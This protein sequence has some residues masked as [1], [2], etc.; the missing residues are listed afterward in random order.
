M[1]MMLLDY[2][3]PN[4]FGETIG[5][6]RHLAW[7]VNVY[8]VT[9]PKVPE[10]GE[11]LNALERVILKLIDAGGVNEVES[12]ANETCIPKDL[13]QCVLLRLQDKS[14]LDEYNQVLAKQRD[15]WAK[16]EEHQCVYVTALLFRELTSGKILPYL[17]FLQ[18][19]NPL[20]KKEE[21]GSFWKL[22]WDDVHR[23]SQPTPRDVISAL[24]GMQLRAIAFGKEIRR[25]P[26]QL[27][28]I[29]DDAELNYLDCPIAIQKSDGE[30]RIADPFGSGC[31]L[32]L[33]NAFGRLLE[34]DSNLGDRFMN[35]K[36]N[37][38]NGGS[39]KRAALNQEPYDNEINWSRYP[40][41]V[42][43]LKLHKKRHRNIQQIHAAI[44]WALFYSCAQRS[45]TS[46]VSRLKLKNQSEHPAL[47][48]KA[49]EDIS[50][51]LP[52]NGLRPLQE[53]KLGS[54]LSGKAELGTVLILSLLMAAGD[55]SHPLHRIASSHQD[56]ITRLFKIKKERDEIGH[57]TGKYRHK[58]I[59]LPEEV[60][61]REVVS[62]LLPTVRFSDNPVSEVNQEIVADSLLDARTSLQ[63]EFGFALFNRLGTNLQDR[64]IGA[65]RFWL[66][67]QDGD[68]ALAFVCDLYAALQST[69]RRSLTGALP[70]EVKDTEYCAKAQE[71]ADAYGLGRLPECLFTAKRS[72][73]RDTLQGNDQTLQ[74]CVVAFILISDFDTLLAIAHVHHSFLADIAH[75]VEQRGHGNEPLPLPKDEILKLR[76]ATFASIK[77]LMEA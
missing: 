38:S 58:D 30:F 54:F 35:W 55:A 70:P 68:D 43:N 29:A 20:K 24:R 69:F 27:I 18:E 53:G 46:A 17:H 13:V 15:K 39:V 62:T 41:L 57:G 37:L 56:F 73:I 63:G 25:P 7:P 4:P 19:D 75:I 67:C 2:G 47:L 36:R 59:E 16:Q 6:K 33:E 21:E 76:K 22:L 40:K 49:A 26:V 50:L 9:L 51:I 77:T 60:F 12:L 28:T 32:V 11:G 64:L 23:K 8:R 31:S 14:Y 65:E 5:G 61:M 71:K 44:E 66:F 1:P 10:V 34:E 52:Q 3:K 48:Q 42:A 45:Y 74:S 72:D